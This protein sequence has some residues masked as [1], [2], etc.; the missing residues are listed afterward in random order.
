M[1]HNAM[2]G[3]MLAKVIGGSKSFIGRES[4]LIVTGPV[5]MQNTKLKLAPRPEWTSFL[6]GNSWH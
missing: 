1:Q 3:V 5:R 2:H 4:R 6:K